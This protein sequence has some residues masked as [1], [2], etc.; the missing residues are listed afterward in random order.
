M[1]NKMKKKSKIRII[2]SFVIISGLLLGVFLWAVNTG[3]LK[4]GGIQLLRGL[5][6]AYDPEVATV[7]DL[8]FPRIII[9]MLVGSAL[10]VSGVLFQAVLKNPLTDPGIIGI[11]SGASF[12]AVLIT[13]CFPSFY[14]G[15]PIAACVGGFVAF[16][17]VYSLSW[18]NGLSPLR[19]ILVGIAVSSMFIGLS[20]SFNSMSGGN[21]SGVASIVEGNIT[22]KTWSDVKMIVY[23]IPI[24][25]VIAFGFS[26][27]CNLLSLDD[28]TARGIGVNVP[29]MRI[30]IS[31][32]AVL[33]ASIS[34][35]VAGVISFVGLLVP[36]MAR[37]LVGNNHKILIPYSALL[38]A[39]VFLLA[40]T[41]GRTIAAP[42]EI[43][44]SVIMAVIGGPCF[45][46]LLRRR[47]SYGS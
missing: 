27:I 5:L 38:G 31:I 43:N 13:A 18:K 34:T 16:L 19:I 6:I 33:L 44:A 32:V 42:Y 14:F 26:G 25:L 45:I 17:I 15:I 11:S 23:Y 9:S 41:L 29:R 20:S 10:A 39:F 35:A 47:S 1:V 46:V 4:V 28:K 21:L 22:M 30:Y 8:R 40:D 2:S 37:N 3:S 12:T 36:H 7:Y 24:C